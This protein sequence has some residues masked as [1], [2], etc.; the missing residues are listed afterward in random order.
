MQTK[1]AAERER[2]YRRIIA[3]AVGAGRI[4][5]SK[6]GTWLNRLRKSPIATNALLAGLT[7]VRTAEPT[8]PEPPA[9]FG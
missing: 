6:R 7:P 2:M 1:T 5:A 4:G 9:W 8:E 3:N